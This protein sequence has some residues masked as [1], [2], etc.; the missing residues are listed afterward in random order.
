[1]MKSRVVHED[2]DRIINASL[3]WQRFEGASIL[4]S[5]AAGMLAGYMVESLL[6][7]KARGAAKPG[8]II[9]LV[10]SIE[11]AEVRFGQDNVLTLIEGDVANLSKIQGPVDFIIHAA[12]NASPKFYGSDPAGVMSANLLGTHSLLELARQKGT[13][14]FLFF[15]SGEIYGDVSA[16]Q[17]PIA[18][19]SFGYLN[20]TDPRSCYAESK[21][22]GE[23]MCVA[24][25]SQYGVPTK[26]VRP[27]HTFGPGIKLDDGRVFADFIS[28]LL[29]NRDI[30]MK[31]DG[32]SKRAFCYVADAAIAYFKILLDGA[33]G[34]AYNVGGDVEI[35][36][37]ELARLL[38]DEFS[39]RGLQVH[40]VTESPVR[41]GYIVSPV[42]RSSP[43]IRRIKALGWAPTTSLSTSFRRTVNHFEQILNQ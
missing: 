36:I 41:P 2:I 31:S 33:T 30:T 37:L 1:M 9:G 10:R 26:I 7:L 19:D 15:S 39:E 27:F 32:S 12:S 42:K 35:S 5:G 17:M 25:A 28:D 22:A 4:I 18:E 3:P 34:T 29:H 24:W 13:R 23:A 14:G 16:D 20:P 6:G 38:V 8:R 43:D 11:R 40:A 21:R